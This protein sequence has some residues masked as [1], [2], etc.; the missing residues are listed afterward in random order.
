[1]CWKQLAVFPI[2]IVLKSYFMNEDILRSQ[3]LMP[4]LFYV[5]NAATNGLLVTHRADGGRGPLLRPQTLGSE[6]CADTSAQCQCHAW[7]QTIVS[8]VALIK[9]HGL[10]I[11]LFFFFDKP[12]LGD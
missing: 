6:H 5:A 4:D 12:S 3:C 10:E 1:M 9:S 8:R 11:N 7:S 2:G